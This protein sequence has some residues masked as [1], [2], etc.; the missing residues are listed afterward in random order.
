MTLTGRCFGSWKAVLLFSTCAALMR[1][2][3][4]QT[5]S[6]DL[7]ALHPGSVLS[8]SV[9]LQNP[10]MLGDSAVIP[11]SFT[12]P[13]DYSPTMLATTLSVT[14]GTPDDQFRFSDISFTNLANNKTY[15]LMVA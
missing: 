4:I 1:A 15:N 14:A 6:I 8:G 3:V 9:I 12:D 11:L 7:S 13:S 2:D 5:L 10:L